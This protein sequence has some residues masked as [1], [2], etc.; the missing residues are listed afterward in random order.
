VSS[1]TT[2][3]LA[4]S[5]SA[6]RS[7]SSSSLPPVPHQPAVACIPPQQL[8]KKVL[9]FQEHWYKEFPWLHYDPA[10]LGVLC[11]LCLLAKSRNLAELAKFS[12]DTFTSHG[13]SNWKKA[14]EKF[15]A[16]EKSHAHRLS[17]ENLHFAAA[18]KGVDVQL[19]HQLNA[20]QKIARTCLLKLISS[21]KF[22]AEQGLALRGKENN[23][24][25]F[26]RY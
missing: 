24:G 25:N 17:K 8:S 15:R 23:S 14:L 3:E 9:T 1:S 16:H 21:L 22:L 13:F 26:S 5:T 12:E 6:L 20:E 2:S 7:E 19:D 18:S 11:H 10:K 4:S